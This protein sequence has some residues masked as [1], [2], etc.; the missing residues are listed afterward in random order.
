MV[1]KAQP[2]EADPSNGPPGHLFIPKA[3][4]SDVLQWGHSSSI[5]CHPG[6]SRILDFIGRRFW[7]PKTSEP[8]LLPAPFVISIRRPDPTHKVF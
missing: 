2:Q 6:A 7:W 1:R 4:R 5:A 3:V 8:R